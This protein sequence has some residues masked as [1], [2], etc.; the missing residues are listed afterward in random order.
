MVSLIRPSQL[1]RV[2]SSQYLLP[3]TLFPAAGNRSTSFIF[4]G[5]AH[6]DGQIADAVVRRKGVG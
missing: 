5:D 6:L 2:Y 1:L 4:S 3:V